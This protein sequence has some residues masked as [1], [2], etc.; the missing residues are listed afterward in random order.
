VLVGDEPGAEF[1]LRLHDD[2]RVGQIHVSGALDG[3]GIERLVE[4]MGVLSARAL[5]VSLE[6]C[7]RCAPSGLAALVEEHA[8]RGGA[9][10]LVAAAAGDVRRTLDAAC[11]AC[12][13]QVFASD[14]AASVAAAIAL[15]ATV[16]LP[17]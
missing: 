6:R 5:V 13:L 7:S 17:D 1:A 9:L 2:G 14:A 12:G 10:Y 15:S 4:A 8:R 11:P 16:S 3:A